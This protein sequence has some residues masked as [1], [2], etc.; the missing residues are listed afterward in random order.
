[1]NTHARINSGLGDLWSYIKDNAE[2]VPAHEVIDLN[3]DN[4][5]KRNKSKENYWTIPLNRDQYIHQI[6][7]ETSF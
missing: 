6:L 7:D 2:L 5:L 1:L 4:L 3:F